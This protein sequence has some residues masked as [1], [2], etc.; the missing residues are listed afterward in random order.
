MFKN[1]DGNEVLKLMSHLIITI[2]LILAYV[3]LTIT[4]Q[5]PAELGTLLSLAVGYW[6]GAVGLN[7]T[8][9]APTQVL[10]VQTIPVADPVQPAVPT[11]PTDQ[12]K[13]A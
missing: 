1:L 8:K 3:Y 12:N 7:L 4:K 11:Q 9:P 5:S 13:G 6:F 2:L 10:P